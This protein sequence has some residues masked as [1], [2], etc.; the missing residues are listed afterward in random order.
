MDDKI[1]LWLGAED[2]DE[3]DRQALETVR[4]LISD[5]ISRPGQP[6]HSA[7][8]SWPGPR[9]GT[10]WPHSRPGPLRM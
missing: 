2:M 9:P 1:R 8:S 4:D 6:V 7:G 5:L 10:G 3:D